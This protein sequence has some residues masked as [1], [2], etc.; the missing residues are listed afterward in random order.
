MAK[1]STKAAHRTD[2]KVVLFWGLILAITALFAVLFV[3]RY[4]ETRIFDSYEDIE[5]ADLNLVVDITSEEN[6]Y[7]V[8]LYSARKNDEGKL[9]DTANSDINKANDVFPTIL[10][11]FNYVR[12]NERK[13]D[14]NVNFLKIYG[15]NVKGN[16]KDKNISG[17][18]VSEIT[19]QV[20]PVL[21]KVD[22]TNNTIVET[23][24]KGNDIQKELSSIMT[25]K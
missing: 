25:K 2:Y 24:V 13:N 7:Y 18:N 20:L 21:V 14:D 16:E 1:N 11:Y 9:V 5:N 12:R 4:N 8:Y 3:V 22:G 15:Y 17:L 6:S 10:S 19:I 23:F